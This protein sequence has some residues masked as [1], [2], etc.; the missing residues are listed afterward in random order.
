M[1]GQNAEQ[2]TLRIELGAL[3]DEIVGRP[4]HQPCRGAVGNARLPGLIM[5]TN[6]NGTAPR[7]LTSAVMN[8]ARNT[9]PTM[10]SIV[11]LRGQ[12]ANPRRRTVE[13][14]ELHGASARKALLLLGVM[15]AH[16]FAEGVGVGVSFGGAGELGVFITTTILATE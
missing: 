5:R 13:I 2:H 11:D 3:G 16:S 6:R 15:T 9:E 7:P 10:A 14:A 4:E 1:T 12:L 8:A